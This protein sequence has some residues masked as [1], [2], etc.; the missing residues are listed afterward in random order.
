MLNNE[1]N[2]PQYPVHQDYPEY[3]T[4]NASW[5]KDGCKATQALNICI[6]F[7]RDRA[8]R[9]DVEPLMKPFFYFKTFCFLFDFFALPVCTLIR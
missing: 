3:S 5:E 8:N 6:R 9:Y 4:L 1:P 7:A 2:V